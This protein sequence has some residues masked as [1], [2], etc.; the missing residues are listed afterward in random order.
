MSIAHETKAQ[1]DTKSMLV[2]LRDILELIKYLLLLFHLLILT[3]GDSYVLFKKRNFKIHMVFKILGKCFSNYGSVAY[4][5][6]VS[7]AHCWPYLHGLVLILL[8]VGQE[9]LMAGAPGLLP[10]LPSYPLSFLQVL[11]LFLRA[12]LPPHG[13]SCVGNSLHSKCLIL[14][15]NPMLL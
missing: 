2:Y 6:W 8:E 5:R 4:F 14:M 3:Y 7:V 11:L 12:L 10:S 13:C 1:L 15:F 9:H